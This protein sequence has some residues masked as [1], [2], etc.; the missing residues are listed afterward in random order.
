MIVELFF[1]ILLFAALFLLLFVLLF[2]IYFLIYLV[3]IIPSTEYH[4]CTLSSIQLYKIGKLFLLNMN[5]EL[6]SD[7]YLPFSFKTLLNCFFTCF[8]VYSVFNA[9]S[10]VY[11]TISNIFIRIWSSTVFLTIWIWSC[12]MLIPDLLQTYL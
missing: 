7:D 9:R 2:L 11:F 1:L 4:V 5:F 3:L 10:F 8:K 12:F 6:M